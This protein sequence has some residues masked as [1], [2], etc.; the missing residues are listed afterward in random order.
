VGQYTSGVICICFV[1]VVWTFATVLKQVI[2]NDLNYNAP[3]ILTYVCN[4]C[5]AV[6]FP[7]HGLLR[8]S[9][10]TEPIPWRRSEEKQGEVRE[11]IV[12]G[13]VIAPI[14]FLA[15]WTYSAGV[16]S[17]SVTASTVISTTSVVWTLIGSVIFLK[18]KLTGMKVF[19]ILCCMAGNAATLLGSSSGTD[20]KGAFSGDLLC[21]L[22]AMLY[23][24]YTTV[25]S[26]LVGE[27]FSVALLFGVIGVAILVFGAPLLFFVQDDLGRMTPEV[28]GL[29]IFNGLFDNVL[30]QFAWAKAVQWTSPTTATVGLSLT[31]PLSVVADILRH[32][33]LS[34]WTF[35]AA[36]L[37]VIGFVAVTL[38]S[39]PASQA[40]MQE[41]VLEAECPS[42]RREP[43]A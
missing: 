41:P 7:L 17:T 38:A 8:C 35:V 33:L 30:S 9:A 14:W 22:A 26:R 39:K 29:L 24:T 25:L 1:A 23:A 11:A 42:S 6:H 13:L 31:I 21:V 32:Q 15:Q 19:G 5:Y 18:E 28:F 34:L 37:V 4:G 2:F 36:V 10:L 16:A 40:V 3:L 43:V 12:A 27:D 20:H